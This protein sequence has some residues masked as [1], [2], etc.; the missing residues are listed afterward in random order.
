MVSVCKSCSVRRWLG[1]QKCVSFTI[2]YDPHY[3]N[4]MRVHKID[5]KCVECPF[6]RKIEWSKVIN[7]WHI[8]QLIN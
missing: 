6:G 1:M 8:F 3:G 2:L 7:Y 5:H 4:I